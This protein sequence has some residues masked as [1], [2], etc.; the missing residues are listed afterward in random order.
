M[1]YQAPSLPNKPPVGGANPYEPGAGS[2]LP[3]APHMPP[4]VYSPA[5]GPTQPQPPNIGF[6]DL[7][8]LP[9]V[10]ANSFPAPPGGASTGSEDV[11]FDDLTRRFEELKKKK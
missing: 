6:M 1:D 10:P 5:A 8:E 9:S 4:P 7:P 2:A 3:P 11:D